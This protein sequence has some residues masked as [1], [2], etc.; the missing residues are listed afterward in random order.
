VYV[1]VDSNEQGGKK[2][3]EKSGRILKINME[4]N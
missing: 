1:L 3:I 4:I 2:K